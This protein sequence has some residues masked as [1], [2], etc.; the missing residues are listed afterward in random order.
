MGQPHRAQERRDDDGQHLVERVAAA[1]PAARRDP[2]R[3]CAGRTGHH[4]SGGTGGQRQ[5][6]SGAQGVHARRRDGRR[7]EA[8]AVEH[9]GDGD[10]RRFRDLHHHV[11]LDRHRRVL[12]N[13]RRQRTTQLAAVGEEQP[14]QRQRGDRDRGQ[15]QP[16]LEGLHECDRP[17]APSD[18]IGDDD[19]ADHQRTD[20]N[21]H[22]QKG[23][24]HQTGALVLRHQ[25]KHANHHHDKHRDLAQPRRAQPELREIGHGVGARPPQRRGDEQQQPEVPGGE[26][27]R[28]P[29]R[30]G[31]VLGDQPRHPEKRCGRKVFA[32][33]GRGVPLRADGARRHQEVGGGAGQ[34][35]PVGADR[36]G[37]HRRC[38][39][40][41]R[42]QGCAG[43]SSPS[44]EHFHLMQL[45]PLNW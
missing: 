11:G 20:P 26:T 22:A 29:Q 17:H 35:H 44:C 2:F 5:G 30:V 6:G 38:Q 23:F 40:R 31:A 18:D 27:D 28:I 15:L 24:Q 3:P 43:H 34:P 12:R 14:E 41:G 33:D 39:Q 4:R 45:A 13:R 8:L 19:P 42:R 16:E 7:V 1:E 37:G 21:R 32:R 36:D 25:V 10:A 9:A